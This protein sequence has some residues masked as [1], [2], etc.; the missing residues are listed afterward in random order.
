M[1]GH[2]YA[3]TIPNV[4]YCRH[5]EVLSASLIM[6]CNGAED[7]RRHPDNDMLRSTAATKSHAAK[8]CLDN[9][10]GSELYLQW[11]GTACSYE[12][13]DASDG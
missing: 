3:S 12:P 2:L 9:T 11:R 7:R 10:L 13:S 1:L 5:K 8:L 4:M 6:C